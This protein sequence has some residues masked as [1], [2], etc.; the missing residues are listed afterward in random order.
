[1]INTS[2][3]QDNENV[4]LFTLE[5]DQLSVVI[6]E[7]GAMIKSIVYKPIQRETVCGLDTYAED[8]NQSFYLGSIIGR[9]SNR[10]AQGKFSLNNQ[11]YQLDV[12][13][14]LHHL[15]G[16]RHGFDK[17]RFE[18]TLEDEVLILTYTSQ[19]GEEAYPG[20]C[21]LTLRYY[22]DASSLVIETSGVCDQDTLFDPTQHTYFNLNETKSP[23]VNHSLFLNS[24]EMYCINDQGVTD[25]TIL[26]TENTI[27]DFSQAK[28]LS[29]CLNEPHIQ[30]SRN[31][32]IDNFYI[33]YN[34]ND[35]FM[36][37]LSVSDVSVSI[38]TDHV[39]AH[40]YTGN[41]LTPL[42]EDNNYP[43][44][45]SYGGICFETQH[46]PNSINFDRSLAPIL[47]ANKP[48]TYRT[49]YHY[50]KGASDGDSNI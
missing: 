36:A 11:S 38:F 21:T 25:N 30:L 46:V 23:I 7:Y 22:L 26:N 47:K 44:L 40:I 49:I 41:Y 12:N 24:H 39:G 8:T 6:S 31:R 2:T 15:H 19:D 48:V 45:T 14:G 32:G 5:N 16:G 3:Y 18:S 1:M 35:A 10:I 13:N 43:F 27:F 34:R 20:T 9:T 28:L 37:T 4:H 29:D 33:K 17:K 50:K 42:D